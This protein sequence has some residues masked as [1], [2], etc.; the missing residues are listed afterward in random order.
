[1]PLFKK[2]IPI[3]LSFLVLVLPLASCGKKEEPVPVEEDGWICA[4]GAA[5]ETAD[6]DQLPSN[7][8]LR[9]NTC[10]QVIRPTVSGDKITLTFSNEY[11][12]IP[13][14][15]E[16]VH[17]AKLLYA[18][19][20]AVDVSTDAV[21]TFGGK[22]D[23]T[24]NAGESVTSDEIEFSFDALELLAVSVKLG[25]YTGG[26]V[27]CHRQANASCWITEGN[28]ASDENLS[29]FKMMG[30]FYYLSRMD[31]WKEAGAKTVVLLG[32]SITDGVGATENLYAAWPDRLAE[33]MQGDPSTE[34]ISVVNMGISGNSLTGEWDGTAKNRLNRDVLSVSGAKY[35][36]LLIGINDIGAAQSDISEAMIKDYK[37][38][39]KQCH[40]NGIKIYAGTLTPVKG[41]FYYSELHEKIRLAVNEFIMSE[42]SGFDGV[43]DFSGAL[44]RDDDPAQMKDEY[45]S[46]WGDYL[47]PGDSGYEKMAKTAYEKL[48]ELWASPPAAEEK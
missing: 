43:I 4:W 46:P 41:N 9:D 28:K 32:D 10:R 31:V 7:P 40:E 21:I 33:L 15:F 29:G 23:V 25:S 26:T 19:S 48:T 13:L 39:I 6:A 11:G 47:H 38:I 24:V 45:N 20:P 35:C 34:N 30:S 8:R 22:E 14:V 42:D 2:F 16:S 5:M 27:T 18:G 1:M 44:C 36:V 3:F 37:E 17:I 12:E